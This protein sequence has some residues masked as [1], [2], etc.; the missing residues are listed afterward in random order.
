MSSVFCGQTLASTESATSGQ[1]ATSQCLSGGVHCNYQY[2]CAFTNA[3]PSRKFVCTPLYTS[4]ELWSD[5]V[6]A[7]RRRA[8]ALCR[9][10]PRRSRMEENKPAHLLLLYD[11]CLVTQHPYAQLIQQQPGGKEVHSRGGGGTGPQ[12]PIPI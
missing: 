2:G 12:G 7:R 4:V 5:P 10:A 1:S 11:D 3:H 9:R 6:G 8:K